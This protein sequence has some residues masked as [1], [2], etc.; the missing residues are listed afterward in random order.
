[1][2]RTQGINQYADGKVVGQDGAVIAGA[3]DEIEI[4]GETP[5]IIEE[6]VNP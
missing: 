2:A 6:R 5:K 4:E 1:L 3:D